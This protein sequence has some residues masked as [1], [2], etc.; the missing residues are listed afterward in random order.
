MQRGCKLAEGFEGFS[1]PKNK[2]R[3]TNKLYS[4]SCVYREGRNPVSYVLQIL[5]LYA[6]M[7]LVNY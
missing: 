2:H 6:G 3:I 4:E 5:E 1:A 7:H